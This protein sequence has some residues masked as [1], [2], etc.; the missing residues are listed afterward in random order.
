MSF[1]RVAVAE[2]E[3]RAIPIDDIRRPLLSPF[4]KTH[5]RLGSLPHAIIDAQFAERSL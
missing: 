2:G 1:T 5:L 3:V 4:Q